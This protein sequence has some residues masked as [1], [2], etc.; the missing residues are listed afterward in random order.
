MGGR[1]VREAGLGERKNQ[2]EAGHC[3]T[4]FS[5]APS[6]ERRGMTRRVPQ[7]GQC[8]HIP[9]WVHLWGKVEPLQSIFEDE[10][11]FA[12]SSKAV[13]SRDLA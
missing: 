12:L 5:A 2:S 3:L 11:K 8:E 6:A 13:L 9:A 10:R 1:V 4:I 7:R